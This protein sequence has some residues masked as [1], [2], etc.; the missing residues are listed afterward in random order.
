MMIGISFRGTHQF[1]SIEL[2]AWKD[3]LP[4]EIDLTASTRPMAL[5]H[6]L[7]LHLAYWWMLILLHRPFYRRTKSDTS[8]IDIDHAKVNSFYPQ[9]ISSSFSFMVFLN[10]KSH[11]SSL[12]GQPSRR[13]HHDDRHCLAQQYLSALLPPDHRP[14]RL[15]RRHRLC[16][17][18]YSSNLGTSSRT[19]HPPGI[20]PSDQ[21]MHGVSRRDRHFL[22]MCL[23]RQKYPHQSPRYATQA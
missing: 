14:D 19:R 7:T 5:P 11:Y 23:E 16:S 12:A 3:N 4:P 2:N 18:R 21:A 15:L 22:E 9:F 17:Q 8:G 20:S 10:L 6:R 1:R 13:E